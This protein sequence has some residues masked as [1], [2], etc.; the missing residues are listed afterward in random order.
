MKLPESWTKVTPLSKILALTLLVCLPFIGFYFGI[1]YQK[2]LC[3]NND[4]V[5]F[6]QASPTPKTK[7]P[8]Q[9]DI[10]SNKQTEVI[11]VTDIKKDYITGGKYGNGIRYKIS[12]IPG[13]DIKREWSDTLFSDDLYLTNIADGNYQLIISQGDQSGFSCVYG[14]S[15]GFEESAGPIEYYEKFV[16]LVDTNGNKF[17]RV[18]FIKDETD[19][20]NRDTIC[21]YN[22][23]EKSYSS[24]TLYGNI[25][26]KL[27]TGY[28][29][30]KIIID[31][32]IL[33]QMD[34]MIRSL[35]AEN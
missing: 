24:T 30:E 10:T 1:K 28:P 20:N 19:Y 33:Q 17:R 29:D 31:K 11:T 21:G 3:Q 8:T 7:I 5:V 12:V 18:D 13:W 2:S 34:T 32:T 35:K 23:E 14:R 16:D 26:Y 6:K 27:P 22:K 25:W 9:T 15:Q 4:I